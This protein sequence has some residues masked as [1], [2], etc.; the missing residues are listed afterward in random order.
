M[1]SGQLSVK[2]RFNDLS[3]HPAHRF[4]AQNNIDGIAGDYVFPNNMTAAAYEDRYTWLFDQHGGIARMP[5]IL[6][7]FY[8]P[9]RDFKGNEI[10]GGIADFLGEKASA[11]YRALLNDGWNR[12]ERANPELKALTF[13]R[14]HAGETYNA[15]MGVT[16]GFNVQDIDFFL[17][18]RRENKI[19][20]MTV[21]NDPAFKKHLDWMQNA[22]SVCERPCWV[23]SLPTM[24]NITGQLKAKRG[25]AP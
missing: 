18:L 21:M 6:K 19:P 16:S 14:T 24:E 8:A 12:L 15:L 25:L 9:E 7:D 23:P 5:E 13:D 20:A 1:A 2:E 3:R 11:Q 17:K 22:A 4:E 10:K